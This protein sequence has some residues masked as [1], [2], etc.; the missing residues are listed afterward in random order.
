[1]AD[2]GTEGSSRSEITVGSKAF[3]L[4]GAIVLV[5]VIAVLILCAV[6]FL[7]HT[8]VAANNISA[9]YD[10]RNFIAVQEQY[11]TY[12][13][14]Y[15][16][17]AGD[18]IE[19]DNAFS[20]LKFSLSGFKPSPGVIITITSGDGADFKG[21]PP[22]KAEAW[23]RD[24]SRAYVYDFSSMKI[25]ERERERNDTSEQEAAAKLPDK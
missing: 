17:S 24:S 2:F 25:T 20:T 13:R 22:F 3:S 11:F 10:L 18:F 12:N 21:C 5:L 7:R 19:A 8:R 9:K 14:R 4:V 23:H 1:M 6:L 15:L 16:G